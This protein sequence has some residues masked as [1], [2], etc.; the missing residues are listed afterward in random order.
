MLQSYT[1]PNIVQGFFEESSQNKGMKAL[2]Q[3]GMVVYSAEKSTVLIDDTFVRE[4]CL[5]LIKRSFE[6]S[7]ST[8]QLFHF[9]SRSC[10]LSCLLGFKGP[11]AVTQSNKPNETCLW[12]TVAIEKAYSKTIVGF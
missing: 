4:G 10:G 7:K 9:G 12:F 5:R 3:C 6:F 2:F 11:W 1:R 8:S